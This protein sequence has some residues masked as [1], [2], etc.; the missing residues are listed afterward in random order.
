MIN[1]MDLHISPLREAI[2]FVPSKPTYV[3]GIMRPDE[4]VFFPL[5]ESPHWLH[6]TNY[7][8]SDTWPGIARAEDMLF[9]ETMAEQL[10]A[11]FGRYS[12]RCGALL[13]YYTRGINRSPAVAIGLNTAFELGHDTAS[14]RAKYT[15]AN[16]YVYYN[17][18]LAGRG[19]H[20]SKDRGFKSNL[21]D[22][23]IEMFGSPDSWWPSK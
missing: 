6:K 4:V 8:F 5:L 3:I 9:D 19:Y 1:V 7:D 17:V 23:E 13:A 22:R 11:E 20:L 14:M 15:E 12:D 16:W 18:L 2:V 10:V 21:L